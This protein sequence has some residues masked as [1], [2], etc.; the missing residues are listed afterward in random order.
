MLELRRRREDPV[1]VVAGVGAEVLEDHR[2][3]ILARHPTCHGEMIGGD[4]RGVRVVDHER[5]HRRAADPR[6]GGGERLAQERHVDRAR[7]GWDQIGAL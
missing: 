5:T 6:I 2:E 7:P 3:E 4:R 1:G